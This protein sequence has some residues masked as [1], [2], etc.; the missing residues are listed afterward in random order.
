M[1][2]VM[3]CLILLYYIHIQIIENDY[4]GYSFDK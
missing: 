1:S 4:I 3:R 2:H